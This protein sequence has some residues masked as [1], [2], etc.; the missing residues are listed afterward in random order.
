MVR[1]APS[2]LLTM[3]PR[4]CAACCECFIQPSSIVLAARRRPSFGFRTLAWRK[5]G[6]RR[7]KGRNQSVVARI[8][9]DAWRLSARRPAFMRRR[10]AL[11]DAPLRSCLRLRKR[12]PLLGGRGLR[13]SGKPQRPAV[14]ELLAG[15]HRAPGR[16]PGAARERGLR[17]PRPRAPA[18]STRA[19]ATGSRP[20]G[21]DRAGGIKS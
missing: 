5:R 9:A 12:G 16:S 20:L 15:G 8:L 21:G 6:G 17:M 11:S 14:S 3:R 4:E 13:A 2:A 19:G 10:A 1:D 7:A 18:R